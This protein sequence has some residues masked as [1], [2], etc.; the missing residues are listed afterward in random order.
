MK[1]FRLL[2]ILI[3]F[4]GCHN[5]SSLPNILLIL[6]DDLGTDQVSSYG[7]AYYETPNID[8]LSKEGMLFQ[9]AYTASAQIITVAREIFDTLLGAFR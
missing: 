9:Q 6:A 5:E 3:L 4:S 8:R 7:N 2:F 1:T